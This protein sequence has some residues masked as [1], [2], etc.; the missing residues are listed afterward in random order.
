MS[1]LVFHAKRELEAAGWFKRDVIRDDGTID[2]AYDGMIG[3]AV[4]ELV[5]RFAAQGHSGMSASIVRGLFHVLADFKPL[6]PLTG[7]DDEW[8]EVGDQDGHPLY[9]NNRCSRVFKCNGVAYDIDGRV[10]EDPC[11]G[12]YTNF[13]SR[14]VVTFPYT[15]KTEIVKVEPVE[16][17]SPD[18]GTGG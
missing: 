10:F 3:P 2:G 18:R 11:G 14:V 13:N 8:N 4:M 1:S 6:G 9:Q 17:A 12:R 16:P 5:Q 7:E 15:P